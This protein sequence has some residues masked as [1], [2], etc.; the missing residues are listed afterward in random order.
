MRALLISEHINLPKLLSAVLSLSP[1]YVEA[2]TNGEA[3]VGVDKLILLRSGFSSDC[4]VE[5]AS[6]KAREFDLLVLP[7]S[8]EM[9]GVAARIA[10]RAGIPY[11]AGATHIASA[12][13]KISASRL[14]Y[15]G[16]GIEVLTADLPAV[17]T[18]DLSGVEANTAPPKSREEVKLS[19]EER[20]RVLERREKIAEVDL[21]KAE[22][23]VSV[24]R[25]LKRKEDL[26]LIRKLA[27]ILKAEI[28]CTRPI[29][30]D[31]KWLPE[32]RHVG[33]T[34]VRVKPKLYLA[35]GISGQIQHVV[36]FRDSETVVSVNIDPEAPIKDVSDY[37]IVA[38]L[39]EFVPKLIE[40]LGGK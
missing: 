6:S 32:E 34:G 8:R 14:C 11:L 15:G 22:V 23:I 13:G 17:V 3:E 21:S 20:V 19:C 2:I 33:M 25:G 39:Y 16:R 40:S 30:A 38:D 9:R 4:L 10:V 27:S 29:S 5:I 7:A 28:A 37:F 18:L 1:S 36:G 12:D 35:I 26:E 31:L 24:G